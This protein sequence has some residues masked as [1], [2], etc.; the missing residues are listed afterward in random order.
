MGREVREM[1]VKRFVHRGLWTP[2][3]PCQ[4]QISRKTVQAP[5]SR[6]RKL[7]FPRADGYLKLLNI[8]C[9]EMPVKENPGQ[10]EKEEDTIFEEED[11]QD[12]EHEW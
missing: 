3:E 7:L 4:P 8:P 6:P 12:L 1:M 2:R 5:R 9:G 10:D 11:A